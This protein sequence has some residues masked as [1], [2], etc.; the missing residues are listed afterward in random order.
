MLEEEVVVGIGVDHGAGMQGP[1]D[2]LTCQNELI[3]VFPIILRQFNAVLPA[4]SSR[5][6]VSWRAC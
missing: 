3:R 6:G 1:L 4:I 5:G 2:H